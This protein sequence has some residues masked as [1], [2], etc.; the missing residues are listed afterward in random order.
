MQLERSGARH[1]ALINHRRRP[2]R[3]EVVLGTM[4]NCPMGKTPWGTYLTCEENWSDIFVK[5][6]RV[7]RA[8]EA[9]RH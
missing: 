2:Q 7:T 6:R 3:Q 4:Q 8:G 9:L 5:K 1:Q